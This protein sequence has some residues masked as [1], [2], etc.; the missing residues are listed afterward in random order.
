MVPASATHLH[1]RSRH[2]LVCLAF[3][4]FTALT[5]A[6]D[7]PPTASP[8]PPG[9]DVTRKLE[10][11]RR[12][13]DRLPLTTARAKAVN[14]LYLATFRHLGLFPTATGAAEVVTQEDLDHLERVVSR[15]HLQRHAVLQALDHWMFLLEQHT[16][17]DERVQAALKLLRSYAVRLEALRLD[18]DEPNKLP[19]CQIR[20]AVAARDVE[21]LAAL[22]EG[23]K[24][25]SDDTLRQFPGA[26]FGQVHTV[27]SKSSHS[28]ASVSLKKLARLRP[29]DPAI[30]TLL[31]NTSRTPAQA[32][33]YAYALLLSDPA[34]PAYHSQLGQVLFNAA[35]GRHVERSPDVRDF[36]EDHDVNAV[37]DSIEHFQEAVRLN[38]EQKRL[39]PHTHYRLGVAFGYS[40]EW[41]TGQSVVAFEAAVREAALVGPGADDAAL[42]HFALAQS[43]QAL[44]RDPNRVIREAE[45]CIKLCNARP[46]P[47]AV[48]G[49]PKPG[50]LKPSAL[51]PFSVPGP[52]EL[53]MAHIVTGRAYLDLGRATDA[54]TPLVTAVRHRPK[55]ASAWFWL[56]RAYFACGEIRQAVEAM[57]HAHKLAP[58]DPEVLSALGE[59]ALAEGNAKQAKESFARAKLEA[60]S[61]SNYSAWNPGRLI[62]TAEGIEQA[63]SLGALQDAVSNTTTVRKVKPTFALGQAAAANKH[64]L[65]ASRIFEAVLKQPDFEYPSGEVTRLAVGSA[66]R[67]GRGGLFG[68]CDRQS[69]AKAYHA[70]A[71][72]WADEELGR[73][74]AELEKISQAKGGLTRGELLT[75]M[76]SFQIDPLLASVREP[77]LQA[78]LGAEERRSWESF[79]DAW[80]ETLLAVRG[81][82]L[83]EYA[84]F[85][86][87]G[88]G[89]L[90]GF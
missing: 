12:D 34:N 36:R 17:E 28:A 31:V 48:P 82:P 29:T 61:S 30:Q 60:K 47:P 19:V 4:G 38:S 9:T 53:V 52:E 6:A 85:G 11:T 67:A 80:N 24:S 78:K 68:D 22:F 3:A 72:K 69:D 86:G 7:P 23:K 25:V 40:D 88:S 71:R 41:H 26:L 8:Q 49:T 57:T 64:Y 50:A 63:V 1:L 65:V 46:Q 16:Q 14:S 75:H 83:S 45:Q 90:G 37:G 13:A 77:Y 74:R 44:G 59:F 58:T 32:S 33:R 73:V 54:A 5:P 84:T 42:Y 89:G 21:A 20:K 76:T 62:S 51:E 2:L 27:L 35:T 81:L 70:L 55:S 18:A 79:W 10:N 66:V 87:K 43:L 56:G 39:D 15:D